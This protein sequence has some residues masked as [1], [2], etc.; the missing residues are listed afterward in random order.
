MPTT[1]AVYPPPHVLPLDLDLNVAQRLADLRSWIEAWRSAD[2][3][4]R[5]QVASLDP[6]R[7]ADVLRGSQI[8]S[9]RR[10]L[11]YQ[12]TRQPIALDPEVVRSIGVATLRRYLTSQYA[13]LTRAE[14]RRCARS[15]TSWRP[16]GTTAAWASSAASCL[17]ASRAPGKAACS[18]GMP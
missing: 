5:Q 17:V 15:S 18:T 11:A 1:A 3:G 12:V 7:R 2:E 13:Q 16:S 10:H 8:A 9:L 14:R 4:L 6:H